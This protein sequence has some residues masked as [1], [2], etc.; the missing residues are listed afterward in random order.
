MEKSIDFKKL[1]MELLY[2]PTLSESAPGP[3]LH[4]PLLTPSPFLTHSD[5]EAVSLGSLS[6]KIKKPT[7]AS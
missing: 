4:R 6:C 7:S 5:S 2:D 3:H 1:K